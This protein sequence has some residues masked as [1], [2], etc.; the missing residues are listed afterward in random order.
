MPLFYTW[1]GATRSCE[2]VLDNDA[3]N[4]V[5]H[6]VSCDQEESHKWRRTKPRY[7]D[8]M[9]RATYHYQVTLQELAG[10]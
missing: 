9:R 4:Q 1:M 2:D 7:R 8:T 5:D 10:L 6:P 3:Q